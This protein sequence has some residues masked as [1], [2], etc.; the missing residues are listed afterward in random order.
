MTN[1]RVQ[2]ITSYRGFWPFYLHEHSKPATRRWHFGGTLSATACVAL[3]IVLGN[4]W[5]L[6]AA[7]IAGYGPA[8][9]G[10]FLVE[11]NHPA[12]FR[13][14]LWSLVSDFR[15]TFTWLAGN[16][17]RELHKAGIEPPDFTADRQRS[18]Y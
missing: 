16:L 10:H 3:A 9:I 7:V 13:Y 5:I 11:K 8:W 12:T 4:P 2:P 1:A 14:P 17:G 15:M 6:I 18:A